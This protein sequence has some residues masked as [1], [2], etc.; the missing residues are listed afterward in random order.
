MTPPARSSLRAMLALACTLAASCAVAVTTLGPSGRAVR[1]AASPS[2]ATA[3][4]WPHPRAAGTRHAQ[5]RAPSVTE[6]PA[7]VTA[8]RA[9][10]RLR[11]WT[12]AR[13]ARA[14]PPSRPEPAPP[15]IRATHRPA[16]R[17]TC[18]AVAPAHVPA[19]APA[20]VPGRGLPR[21]SA[22]RRGGLARRRRGR[23]TTGKVFFTMDAQDYVCSAAVVASPAADV[24]ITAA[25][26]VKNGTGSWAVNWTFVP[27]FTR[28]SRPYGSWTA[29]HF[30]VAPPV[31][32]RGQR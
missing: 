21:Y 6:H 8:G 24:V 28:G 2:T 22:H 12:A 11:Y 9:G 23:R 5:S 7:A 20:G 26:C 4:E 1:A 16:R 3:P 13:M 27:G 25:H 29:H 32:T 30:F 19:A 31:E 10:A 15:G 18:T 17:L 14:R